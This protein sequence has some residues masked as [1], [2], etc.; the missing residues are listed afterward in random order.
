[1]Q[2]RRDIASFHLAMQCLFM[3]KINYDL[4]MKKEIE[5]VKKL[6]K[7]PKLL[8]H[9]CCAPCSTHTFNVLTPYFEV[10]IYY[11]N[12]NIFPESEYNR[13]KEELIRF[14]SEYNEENNTNIEMIFPPYE[15]NEFMS[16]LRQFALEKEGGKRCFLC[17]EKRINETLKYASE[18]GYDYVTTSL[19]ISSHKNSQI[20]NEIAK[21]LSKNYPSVK[22]LYSD[23][24]K[25]NANLVIKKMSEEHHLYK[26][27]YCGCEYSIRV[28]KD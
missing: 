18:N 11:A 26:Q 24:K 5:E 1:M 21:N 17:Y 19:T 28:P 27:N 8:L 4:I 20:I 3:D 13:R 7:K 16:E 15:H 6:P 23:F 12:S 9:V 25:N 2:L 14:V 10:T 22:Y